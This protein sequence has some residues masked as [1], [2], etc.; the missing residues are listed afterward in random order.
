MAKLTDEDKKNIIAEYV[1]NKGK[2]TQDFLAKKYKVSNNTISRV[3][4]S[5][6]EFTE[7]VNNKKVENERS[8][9]AHFAEKKGRC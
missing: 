9:L 2:V 6:P 4:N 5:D 7:K 1:T 3:I 8:V